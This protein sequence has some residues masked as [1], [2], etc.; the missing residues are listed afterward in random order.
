MFCAAASFVDLYASL[1]AAR[2]QFAQVVQGD[3][4]VS[5]NQCRPAR[6]CLPDDIPGR[7]PLSLQTL[8]QDQPPGASVDTMSNRLQ[9]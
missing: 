6:A 5:I 9:N 3:H 8:H 7:L 1:I 4:V 2:R